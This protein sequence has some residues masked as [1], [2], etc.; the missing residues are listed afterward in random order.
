MPHQDRQIGMGKHVPRDA[1]EQQLNSRMVS[2]RTYYQEVSP[3]PM[4]LIE[5]RPPK[6]DAAFMGWISASTP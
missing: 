6:R 3:E 1:A 4:G 5:Q 2:M